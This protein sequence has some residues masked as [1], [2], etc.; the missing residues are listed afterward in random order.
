MPIFKMHGVV[1]ANYTVAGHMSNKLQEMCCGTPQKNNRL[2]SLFY[3]SQC[4]VVVECSIDT[5]FSV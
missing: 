4:I 3:R 1:N 5:M 2:M